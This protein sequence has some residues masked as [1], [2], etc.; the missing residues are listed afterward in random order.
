MKFIPRSSAT[1]TARIA[2]LMSMLR[3]SAPSD[4]APKLIVQ[5]QGLLMQLGDLQQQLD[6]REKELQKLREELS[7]K[8]VALEKSDRERRAAELAIQRLSMQLAARR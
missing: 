6:T 4:E 8:E 5:V 7:V 1:C 3:N 2:S